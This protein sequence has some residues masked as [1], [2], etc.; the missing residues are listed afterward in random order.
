MGAGEGANPGNKSCSENWKQTEYDSS[1]R[2]QRQLQ[3][4]TQLPAIVGKIWRLKGE[5]EKASRVSRYPEH[6]NDMLVKQSGVP[7]FLLSLLPVSFPWLLLA[8]PA[9]GG[10]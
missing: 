3:A 5:K 8:N 7:A 9:E 2:R 1:L 6:G 4:A 10:D